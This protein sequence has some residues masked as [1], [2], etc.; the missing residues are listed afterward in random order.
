MHFTFDLFLAVS[1]I[2]IYIFLYFRDIKC[3]NLLV[4]A[5]GSVKLADFGLAKVLFSSSYFNLLS[6][7]L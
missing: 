2:Y 7:F 6:C 3:A 4:D 1:I 5:N